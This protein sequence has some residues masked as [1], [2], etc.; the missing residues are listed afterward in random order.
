MIRIINIRNKM[1]RKINLI[2]SN[3]Q[4]EYIENLFILASIFSLLVVVEIPYL[5]ALRASF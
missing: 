3:L 1:S 2:Q 4:N 5:A